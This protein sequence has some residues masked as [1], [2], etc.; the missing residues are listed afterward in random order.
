M[1]TLTPDEMASTLLF[2]GS[3]AARGVNG[4]N[5]LVDQG[6]VGAGAT[7]AFESP[8]IKAMLGLA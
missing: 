5:L 1:Q 3:D 2:L 6:Q 4:V 7:D 8:P